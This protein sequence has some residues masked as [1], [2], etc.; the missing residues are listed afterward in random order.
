MRFGITFGITKFGIPNFDPVNF[1]MTGTHLPLL[2]K[3]HRYMYTVQ[4]L[5]ELKFVIPNFC[6]PIVIPSDMRLGR[7]LVIQLIR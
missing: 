5:T 3:Y 1:C 6:I 7:N 4:T 2:R